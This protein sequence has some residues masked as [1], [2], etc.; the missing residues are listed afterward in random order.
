[1][2]WIVYEK[3]KAS[4]RFLRPVHSPHSP[5]KG[6]Q[7]ASETPPVRYFLAAA[8][9]KVVAVCATYPHEVVRT[10]LR[11]QARNGAF[12]YTGFVSTLR[13]IAREEGVR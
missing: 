1:M 6:T 4:E 11:E 10:R 13:T 9:S 2:Q 3:I 7:A 8:V 5:S 12:K